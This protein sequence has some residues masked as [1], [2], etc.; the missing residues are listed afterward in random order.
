MQS[1][2]SGGIVQHNLENLSAEEVGQA[3]RTSIHESLLLWTREGGGRRVVGSRI[4]S[5][6]SIHAITI[7]MTVDMAIDMAICRAIY[8]ANAILSS[9]A[10]DERHVAV[11]SAAE[12]FG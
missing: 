8:R 10:Q 2:S 11:L 12:T 1:V 4:V 9:V 6:F 5:I 3:I 7:D